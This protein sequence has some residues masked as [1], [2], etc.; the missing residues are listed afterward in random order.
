MDK[1]QIEKLVAEIK[2]GDLERFGEVIEALQQPIFTYCYHMLGHRQEAEDAVQEVFIKAY[3]HID[4]YTKTLSFSAW[5]YKIAYHHCLNLIKRKKLY[6]MVP[7]L[8]KE[9]SV[10]DSTASDYLSEP[11]H[12]ALSQLNAEERNVIILRV[13]EE[14]TYEELAAILQKNPAAV[15]KQYE[16]AV[17]RCKKYVQMQKG[18]D[19]NEAFK[20]IR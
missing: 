10:E 8:Q 12:V 5:V 3:E 13:V 14:K 2:T 7:F 15:R 6:R 11:L 9:L 4:K 19:E 16:R 17:K 1:E 18:G 20:V